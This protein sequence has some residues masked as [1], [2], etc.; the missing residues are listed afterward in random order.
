[1]NLAALLNPER[2]SGVRLVPEAHYVVTYRTRDGGRH[3]FE[4]FSRETH[5]PSVR[6]E[7]AAFIARRF[8]LTFVEEGSLAIQRV[9]A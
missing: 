6:K 7:V 5:F 4:H 2:E 1:M 9:R 8:T 3:K